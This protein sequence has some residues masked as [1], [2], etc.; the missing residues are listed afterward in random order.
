[1]L[2][3]VEGEGL[4]LLVGPRGSTLQAI[5]ELVRAVVQHGLS[6][7]SARL[8]VDVGGYRE[9]RREALAAFARQ[10]ADEVRDTD[11]ER[12]L[13][14][15][16]PPD[17]KV[18]HDTVA[19]ID[20]VDDELRGRGAPPPRG[21]PARVR[22]WMRTEALLEILTEAQA[23]GFL[24]PGDPASHIEHALGLR[25]GR[26]R[27]SRRRPGRFADLGTGGGVPGLVLAEYWPDSAGDA[28]SRPRTGVS[29]RCP[30]WVDTL[31]IE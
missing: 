30:R 15:M 13:E 24:G 22:A 18:V 26:A 2:V 21:D 9:R 3:A 8:R 1:M 27:G 6:G 19:E 12:A 5:E 31:A 10:V 14:P 28:R 29:A 25:R 4:G 23:L 17:R 16:N 11:L 20:G 7:R